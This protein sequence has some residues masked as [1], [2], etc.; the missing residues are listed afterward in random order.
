MFTE[1]VDDAPSECDLDTGVTFD[2]VIDNDGDADVL[3]GGIQAI[4]DLVREKAP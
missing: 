1:G 3:E 2:I 4:L